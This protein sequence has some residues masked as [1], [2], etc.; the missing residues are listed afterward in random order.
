MESRIVDPGPAAIRLKRAIVGMDAEDVRTASGAWLAGAGEI[1]AVREAMTSAAVEIRAGFGEDSELGKQAF[2]AFVNA[3]ARLEVHETRLNAA[4][5][6]LEGVSESMRRAELAARDLPD[7]PVIGPPRPPDGPLV[8]FQVDDVAG[9]PGLQPE[10]GLL[11]EQARRR[12]AGAHLF[13]DPGPGEDRANRALQEL[14]QR[15]LEAIEALS[16]IE[17]PDT[18]VNPRPVDEP[19]IA[20]EPRGPRPGGA[21][22]PAGLAAAGLLAAPGLRGITAALSRGGTLGKA[23][24]IGTTSRVGGP[25]TLG[26]GSGAVRGGAGL[27][28]PVSRGGAGGRGGRSIRKPARGANRDLYDDGE[29]WIDDEGSGPGVLA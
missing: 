8:A 22:A 7:L 16:E 17:A 12:P 20:E 2:A 13:E 27:G 21:G 11:G 29:D 18:V 15:Q 19:P 6:G 9:L 3:A 25:G 24:P 4:G 1:T 14:D 10:A 5:V 28:A 26:G 23:A